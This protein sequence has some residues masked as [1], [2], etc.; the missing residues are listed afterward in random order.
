[1]G[2]DSD[3]FVA[4]DVIRPA[5]VLS[6][7]HARLILAGLAADDV[8]S[9]GHWRTRVGTWRRYDRP[10]EPGESEPGNTVHLGTISCVYDSP[11]RFCVTVFRVSLTSG[12]LR[13]G[14]TTE[15]LCE[16]AFKHAGL[17]L[18]DCPRAT[19]SAPPRPFDPLARNDRPA[20]LTAPATSRRRSV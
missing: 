12:G 6:E 20:S 15:T 10:W 9:G 19:L 5:A 16:E 18:R 1:M 11:A 2:M 7:G 3:L 13:Q 17:T 14:W 8:L 4:H